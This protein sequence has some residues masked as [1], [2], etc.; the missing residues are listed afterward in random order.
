MIRMLISDG[1][2]NIDRRRLKSLVSRVL[3]SETAEKSS[4]NIVYCTDKLIGELNR[5]FLRKRGT[6][7]VLAFELADTDNRGFL[8]EIYV[9]LQQ[10]RRQ[11]EENNINY[12][13]EVGRLTVHGV[14]HL[15]GYDDLKDANR[16]KMWN[17]QESYLEEWIK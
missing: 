11:A 3:E 1:R 15:L 9:N 8:G 7:D 10:A 14:L 6:T 4:V 2:F 17:R 13:E 16:R 5:R 12:K